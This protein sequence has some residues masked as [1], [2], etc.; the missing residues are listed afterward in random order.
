M[1]NL[2]RVRGS[3]KWKRIKKKQQQHSG[4][5]KK[6]IKRHA[7]KILLFDKK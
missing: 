2:E 6:I 1:R 7:Q 5:K 3:K 4:G